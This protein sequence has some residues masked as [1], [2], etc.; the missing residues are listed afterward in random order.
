M[1]RLPVFQFTHPRGGA[2]RCSGSGSWGTVFL[3]IHAPTWGGCDGE[4]FSNI[5]TVDPFQLTHPRRGA[6][7]EVSPLFQF[8][9]PRE[10]CDLPFHKEIVGYVS[11]HAPT[12][13]VRRSEPIGRTT[14]VCFNSRTHVGGATDETFHQATGLYKFQFTHPHGDATAIGRYVVEQIYLFQ[15]THPR[16]G[17][18]DNFDDIIALLEFQFTHPRGGVRRHLRNYVMITRFNSR[19]HVGGTTSIYSV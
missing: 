17:A 18:M 3:S 13:G 8:T 5:M 4:Y 1:G 16:G 10:G 9:H 6:T 19:T 2:T 12:W 11:T 7:I 14:T 15:F